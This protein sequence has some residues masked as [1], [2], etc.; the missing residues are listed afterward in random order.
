MTDELVQAEMDESGEL[1]HGVVEMGVS[2]LSRVIA[3]QIS[4]RINTEAFNREKKVAHSKS[5]VYS[6]PSL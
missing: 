1:E 5:V 2:Q 6:S 3:S 4:E